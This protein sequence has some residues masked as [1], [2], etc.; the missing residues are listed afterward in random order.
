MRY[1]VDASVAVRWYLADE[2]APAADAVLERLLSEPGLFAVP[3]LFFFEVLAV[4]ARTHP[5]CERVYADTFL[6]ATEGG[7]LRYPMT[8][9]LA[10]GC[11]PFVAS[12]L[13]AYDAAYAS[14]A[15]ELGGVWLTFD[16]EAH[17]AIAAAGL[18]CDLHESLPRDW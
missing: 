2:A 12:G 9:T 5:D 15:R 8:E 7:M 11:A 3:E 1:I 10:R 13:T 16:R 18:S 17:R 4:L 6:T 14:L